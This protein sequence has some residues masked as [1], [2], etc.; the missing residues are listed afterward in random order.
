M[1]FVYLAK[2]LNIVDV[3]LHFAS[4]DIAHLDLMFGLSPENVKVEGYSQLHPQ[5]L[6]FDCHQSL[7]NG[8]YTSSTMLSFLSRNIKLSND[9]NS[10][11]LE[12]MIT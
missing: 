8:N 10:L 7:A 3:S 4:S 12:A 5:S 1:S 9:I 2:C 11:H 6:F